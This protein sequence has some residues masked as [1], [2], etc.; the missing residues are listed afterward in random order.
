[1]NPLNHIQDTKNID[2]G[3]PSDHSANLIYLKFKN[4]KNYKVFPD[5][6]INWNLLL[7]EDVKSTRYKVLSVESRIINFGQQNKLSYSQCYR[8][9][10]KALGK[11]T[12]CA[13]AKSKDWCN[14]SKDIIQPIVNK[15]I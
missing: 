6:L 1:M 9:I 14:L 13:K 7:D 12:S 3:I 15:K 11:V 2:F 10:M 8:E 5:E 4:P